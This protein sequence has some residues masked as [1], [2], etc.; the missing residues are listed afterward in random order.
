MPRGAAP[1]RYAALLRGV[2]PTN[3]AMPALRAAF[4][5][6]GFTDVATVLASGNVL[7]TAPAAREAALE[8]AA[9]A[10]MT[11]VLGKAFFTI[12]RPVSALRAL[13]A[14][15]P[16]R[17][18]PGPATAKRVVS[19][20][21]RA[22]RSPPALPISRDGATIFALVDR[23]AYTAYL[24]SPKGPVFMALIAQAFG[25]EVTTRTRDTILRLAR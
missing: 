24:P 10:A 19:L 2:M 25:D 16:W 5:A 13:I 11:E 17:A 20:L 23:A 18:Y 6:A 4:E 21:R 22:P 1:T 3:V 14:A 12:V 9:E 7:F 8:R 15:D